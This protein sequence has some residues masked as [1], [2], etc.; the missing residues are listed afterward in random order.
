MVETPSLVA[1]VT[2]VRR[3]ASRDP[4]GPDHSDHLPRETKADRSS[5]LSRDTRRRPA[6]QVRAARHPHHGS[7]VAAHVALPLDL[8]RSQ[9][10]LME[11]RSRERN[12]IQ[13]ATHRGIDV[14]EM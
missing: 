3:D 6:E 4:E 7:H 1:G 14:S 12:S 9:Q 5:Q 11:S 10:L 8:L 2:V 13:V